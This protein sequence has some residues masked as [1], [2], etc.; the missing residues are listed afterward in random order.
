LWRNP[1]WATGAPGQPPASASKCR[2][3]SR[4]RQAPFLAADL[5]M[6]YR[7]K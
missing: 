7:R 1:R 2:V 5:S 6:A 4:I 3:L